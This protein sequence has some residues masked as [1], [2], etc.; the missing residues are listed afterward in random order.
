MFSISNVIYGYDKFHT[1]EL[2]F[3]L[4]SLLVLQDVV[5]QYP[6]SCPVEWV[7]A[8]DPLFLLYT[9]GS[10]GKPKVFVCCYCCTPSMFLF[11]SFLYL[12]L[13][14]SNVYVPKRVSCIQLVVTWCTLQQHS[15]M[16]LTTSSLTS[17]GIPQK[18]FP[19]PFLSLTC[20]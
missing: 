15:S 10:T 9:S 11:P 13:L 3:F 2:F 19:L 16:H 18:H 20:S 1:F 8:E 6:T 7:D 5:P 12:M 4:L 17:T 14:L